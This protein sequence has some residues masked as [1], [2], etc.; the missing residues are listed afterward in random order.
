MVL[1]GETERGE[2]NAELRMAADGLVSTLIEAALVATEAGR[3]VV[4]GLAI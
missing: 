2:E 4:S 3:W 1:D